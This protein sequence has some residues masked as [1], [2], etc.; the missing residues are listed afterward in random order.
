MAF[1]QIREESIDPKSLVGVGDVYEL[2]ICHIHKELP[3]WQLLMYVGLND[4]LDAHHV[5]YV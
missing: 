5:D 1:I 3:V 4:S 2:S